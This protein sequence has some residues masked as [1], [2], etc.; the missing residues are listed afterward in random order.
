M[1]QLRKYEELKDRPVSPILF[2]HR[3]T[4]EKLGLITNVWYVLEKGGLS[5][6]RPP[7][8]APFTYR[9]LTI[10][11]FSTVWFSRPTNHPSEIDS[12]SSFRRL[13]RTWY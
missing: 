4:L 8:I 11:L 7:F 10:E 6:L 9:N 3:D 13:N 1:R 2:L 12:D 5:E